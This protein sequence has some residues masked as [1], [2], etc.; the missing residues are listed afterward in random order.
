MKRILLTGMALVVFSGAARSC[1]YCFISEHGYV[2]AINR[3][4]IRVDSRF[5]SFSGLTNSPA[6]VDN[7]T[8]AYTTI[9]FT[10]N[11]ATG[12]WGYTFAVPYDYRLQ[13]NTYI[14][15]PVLHLEHVGREVPPADSSS[16]ETQRARGV[17]DAM[18]L[19]RYAVF[20][21]SGD[22]FSAIF[23]Q[24]GVKLATGS[25]AARDGSGLLLHPHLQAGTG[26]TLALIGASGSYGSPKQS[27]DGSLLAGIPVHAYGPYREP[28]SLN[29]D[30]SFRFRLLPEDAEDGPMLIQH[31]GVIGRVSWKEHYNGVEV[32]DSGGHYL[33]LNAG[34][35]FYPLPGFD[36]DLFGQFPVIKN[37][38]GNQLDELFRIASGIQVAL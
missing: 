24:A 14:G 11:Y 13:R 5:Q 29:Y 25:I 4:L 22:N 3:T 34:L 15:A 30:V 18:A 28:G 16:I 21:H 23:L 7:V 38:A 32:A 8:A 27:I 31:I 6:S 36:V 19:I 33:F 2:F 20:Q 17:G 37:L 26:T 35:A 12:Q 1:E 9:L 10:V